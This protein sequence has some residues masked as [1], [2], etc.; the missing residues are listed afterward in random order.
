MKDSRERRARHSKPGCGVR[1]FDPER[2]QNVFAQQLAG[3]WM[4]F[5]HGVR[6]PQ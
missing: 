4:I 6:F 2:Q 5:H 1:N 3:M